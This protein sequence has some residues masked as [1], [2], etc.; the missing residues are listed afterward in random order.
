M[1]ELLDTQTSM[2]MLAGRVVRRRLVNLIILSESF[3]IERI[4]NEAR[5]ERIGLF[6]DFDEQAIELYD[7]Y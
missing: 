1:L 3:R 7:V 4:K 5:I 2:R 6:G